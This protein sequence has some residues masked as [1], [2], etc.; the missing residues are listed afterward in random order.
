MQ[1]SRPPQIGS[2]QPD[3][4]VQPN[5][6]TLEWG[7]SPY[8]IMADVQDRSP[9]VPAGYPMPLY[10]GDYV[11]N[12]SANWEEN[13]QVAV[14]QLAPVPLTILALIPFWDTGDD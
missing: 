12:L 14:Q 2:N 7:V 4:S 1:D 9:S 3:Q 8:G 11:D 5:H 10:T 6:A 13:A